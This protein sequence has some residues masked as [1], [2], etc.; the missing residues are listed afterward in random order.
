MRSLRFIWF[1]LLLILLAGTAI[2]Q[3]S[4]DFV[5]DRGPGTATLEIEHSWLIHPGSGSYGLTQFSD[6]TG[7]DAPWVRH[8][9]IHFGAH[10][11]TVRLP[12]IAVAAIALLAASSAILLAVRC[13]FTRHNGH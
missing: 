13:R 2:A 4:L 7:A 12:A 11:F 5:P 6:R 9:S 8:T 1:G 3:V 10:Q